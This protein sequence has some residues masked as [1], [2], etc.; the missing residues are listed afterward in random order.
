MDTL[1]KG[2]IRVQ[3]RTAQDFITLFRTVV[4]K[5]GIV[6]S[7]IFPLMFLDHGWPQVTET[8]DKGGHCVELLTTLYT[9]GPSFNLQV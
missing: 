7:G 6:M 5:R 9:H 2:M 8:T 1:D 3:G 4:F